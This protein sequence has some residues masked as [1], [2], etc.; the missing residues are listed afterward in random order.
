MAHHIR[1]NGS[2]QEFA[3]HMITRLG[4]ILHYSAYAEPKHAAAEAAAA[5]WD[6][7]DAWAAKHSRK[8]GA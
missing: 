2:V 3:A 4:G 8:A 7:P 1:H 5:E 6:T